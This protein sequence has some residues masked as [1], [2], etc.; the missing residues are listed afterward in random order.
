VQEYIHFSTAEFVNH[1]VLLFHLD[2]CLSLKWF[3]PKCKM[4]YEKYIYASRHRLFFCGTCSYR[5]SLKLL[6]RHVQ[7]LIFIIRKLEDVAQDAC[8]WS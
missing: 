3:L 6:E 5:D 4:R 8:R 7:G 1:R 2:M